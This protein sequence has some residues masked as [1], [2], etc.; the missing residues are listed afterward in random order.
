MTEVALLETVEGME[1]GKKSC[2]QSIG[3]NV[4]VRHN[5]EQEVL[6]NSISGSRN[7]CQLDLML[8]LK[9]GQVVVF[10][11]KSG[12]MDSVNAKSREFTAYALSGVYGKPVL[13]VPLLSQDICL[14]DELP[15]NLELIFEEF[16]EAYNPYGREGIYRDK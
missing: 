9:S 13:V 8:L 6:I 1:P 15:R 14:L 7:F 11:C 4:D 2:F 5:N 10:E 3:F 16:S 12:N